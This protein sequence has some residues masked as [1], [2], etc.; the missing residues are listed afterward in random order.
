MHQSIQEGGKPCS[1]DAPW[2]GIEFALSESDWWRC[3]YFIVAAW[4]EDHLCITLHIS[5]RNLGVSEFLGGISPQ[6]A[7]M[8]RYSSSQIVSVDIKF[9]NRHY[10]S[11]G[12]TVRRHETSGLSFLQRR[13][14][15]G[16][17]CR[18]RWRIF[19]HQQSILN[20]LPILGQMMI[21]SFGIHVQLLF[22]PA[23]SSLPSVMRSQ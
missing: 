4:M 6:T 14:R 8:S 10:C 16:R 17:S 13:I 11:F 5:G 15:A 19:R 22:V 12:F 18:N 20:E 2:C 1:L 3:P 7:S 23:I 9:R 21:D